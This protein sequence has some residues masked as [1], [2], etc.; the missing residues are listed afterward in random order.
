MKKAYI[1]QRK[2]SSYYTKLIFMKILKM[3]LYQEE[4]IIY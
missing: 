4:N 2:D 1:L 3:F